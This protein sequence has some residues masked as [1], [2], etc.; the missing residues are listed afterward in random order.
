MEQSERG[1]LLTTFAVLFV[2]LAIS[3][4]LKP[5]HIDPNAALVFFGIKTTG[6]ANAILAP[7]FGIF[8]LVY[9]FGIWRMKRWALPIAYGYAAYVI[10]NMILF[11]VRNAHPSDRHSPFFLILT[12]AVAIGVPLASA[13][14]LSRRKQQLT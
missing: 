11:S 6:L 9:A 14:M 2:I 7:L 3:N 4:F 8:L 10:L 1:W 5:F 13:F 12:R